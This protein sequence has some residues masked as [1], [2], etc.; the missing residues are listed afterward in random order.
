MRF[1]VLISAVFFLLSCG[2]KAEN[3][4]EES[5]QTVSNQLTLTAAQLKSANLQIGKMEYRVVASILKLNGKMDVPPQN[6]V[7]ISMPLGGYLASTKLL[8]GM[9]V[10]KG[11]VIAVMEDQQYIQLQQ[12]YLTTKAQLKFAEAELNRQKEL[13]KTQS[14]SD[15][16]LQLA[17][18]EYTTNKVALKS[19][20]EKLNLI[21]VAVARLNEDNITKS[22]KIL[23]PIDGYVSSVKCNVGKYV[24]PSEVLFELIDPSD[25]HL[26]LNVYEKDLSKIEIGQKL[27]AYTNSDPEKRY[28][29]EIILIS[30]DISKL[31]AAEV[32]CHFEKYDKS[33]FPGMYMN[34]EVEIKSHKVLTLPEHAIVNFEGKNYIFIQT[35]S[36][37]FKMEEVSLGVTEAGFTEILNASMFENQQVVTEG[38]YTLLMALKNKLEE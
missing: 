22:V 36:Q 4:N 1:L 31:R 13:N 11:E 12:E 2:S 26:N 18:M 27:F 3:T 24:T 8:P 14:A 35:D 21:N 38:A 17:Q 10:R 20:A 32:H 15:K 7:S 23:S 34:A 28:P 9:R 5:T 19:L 29:C 37:K 16:V 33:L 6:L 25:I 30:Q